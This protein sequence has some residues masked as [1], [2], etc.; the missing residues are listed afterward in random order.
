MSEPLTPESEAYLRSLVRLLFATLDAARAAPSDGLREAL[1]DSRTHAVSMQDY[2]DGK[3]VECLDAMAVRAVLAATPTEERLDADGWA[4]ECASCDR[5]VPPM[6]MCET[7]G[8][9]GVMRVDP[10]PTDWMAN[11]ARD[12]GRSDL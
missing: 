4:W 7:C 8:V 9:F 10:D 11:D 3:F 12:G 6:G 1:N 5:P 2:R